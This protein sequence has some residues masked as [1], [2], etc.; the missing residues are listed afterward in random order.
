MAVSSG[1]GELVQLSKI[2]DR[3]NLEASLRSNIIGQ[4]EVIQ[5]IIDNYEIWQ[6]GLTDHVKPITSFLLL[7]PTGTGKTEVVRALARSRAVTNQ[8][9]DIL[10]DTGAL[11]E[12]NCAELINRHDIARIIGA[13]P[14][15]TGYNDPPLISQKIIDQ[16]NETVNFVVILFDEIEKADVTIQDVLLRILDEGVLGIGNNQEVRFDK[17]MIFM[18]S[19][20]GADEI[21]DLL[22][23][24]M[25]FTCRQTDTDQRDELKSKI[26]G[27]AFNALEKYFRPEFIG[28]IENKFV[29]NI[30]SE[31][32][33]SQILE[34]QLK[35]LQDLIVRR[36]EGQMFVLQLT[37]DAKQFLLEE[38]T[39]LKYGARPLRHSI[40]MHLTRPISLFINRN[41]IEE[42]DCLEVDYN[43]RNRGLALN[44]VR[45]GSL[46]LGRR[47][48]SNTS[49]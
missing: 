11:I 28:R 24:R 16:L 41:R 29:S 18:T 47:V 26:S 20:L 6:A 19:N 49:N 39:N 48:Q 15:Y 25:G 45:K 37:D 38:G 40:K 36:L 32:Q 35:N 30:L 23:P 22:N 17:T 21:S 3:E 44:R 34:K 31:A 1:P 27:V 12:V 4:E 13:P 14:G 5:S 46:V 43:S 7:G 2:K 9:H 10:D 33:L 42:G 8:G